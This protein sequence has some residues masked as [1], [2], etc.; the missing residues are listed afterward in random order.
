MSTN[1]SIAI[2]IRRAS[3]WQ[4]TLG[5]PLHRNHR[6]SEPFTLPLLSF[7]SALHLLLILRSAATKNLRHMSGASP[8]ER[9]P[10][11]TEERQ[12]I[13]YIWGGLP[14]LSILQFM[15]NST[16]R[17]VRDGILDSERPDTTGPRPQR[18]RTQDCPR[19]PGPPPH[20]AAVGRWPGRHPEGPAPPWW[21]PYGPAGASPEAP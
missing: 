2:I 8:S 20:P 21:R 18:D 6:H 4:V 13:K 15:T 11:M 14:H 10:V 7:L 17:P 19:S 1:I 16:G 5:T 9:P 12:K 3:E